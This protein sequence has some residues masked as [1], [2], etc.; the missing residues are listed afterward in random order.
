MQ[1]RDQSIKSVVYL[2]YRLSCME[3]GPDL[4]SKKYV[5]IRGSIPFLPQGSAVRSSGASQ[6]GLAAIET[7]AA[8]SSAPVR[9]LLCCCGN[10]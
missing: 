5:L 3:R 10:G 4:S 8:L 9:A 7:C 2:C 6:A 1:P